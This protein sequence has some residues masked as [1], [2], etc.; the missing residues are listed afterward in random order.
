MVV[1]SLQSCP[2]LCNPIDHSLPGSLVHGVLV[3][4]KVAQSCPTLCDPMDYT[5]HGILRH[6]QKDGIP[7]HPKGKKKSLSVVPNLTSKYICV[8]QTYQ[9][10]ILSFVFTLNCD[11]KLLD[12]L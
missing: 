4:V 7:V 11:Q 10:E 2:T 12:H 1:Q 8:A 9:W 5:V 6:L 3:K